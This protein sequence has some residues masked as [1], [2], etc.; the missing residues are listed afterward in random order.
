MAAPIYIPDHAAQSVGHLTESFQDA[1]VTTALLS[2]F[3]NQIQALEKAM[4][5]VL[6]EGL[7]GSATVLFP[8]LPPDPATGAVDLTGA[9]QGTVNLDGSGVGLD[10][11]GSILRQPRAGLSDAD[12][13]VLLKAAILVYRSRGKTK[14]IEAILAACT[15]V[16]SVWDYQ[17]AYPCGFV[18]RVYGPSGP[19]PLGAF[20]RK[21]AGSGVKVWFESNASL[22]ATTL[23]GDSVSGGVAGNV[24]GVLLGD[25]SHGGVS[26]AGTGSNSTTL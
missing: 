7:L 8:V 1:Q 4:F 12:Y 2:A 6:Y 25:S 16:G 10:Q 22:L 17:P 3:T 13:R 18:A 21:A 23:F 20:L 9:V 11:L 24:P 19:A 5:Q 14:D 15:P 26:G